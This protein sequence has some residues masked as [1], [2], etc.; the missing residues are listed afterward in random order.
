MGNFCTK[1]HTTVIEMFAKYFVMF[2]VLRDK[3][4]VVFGG[5]WLTSDGSLV[6]VF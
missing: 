6:F 5:F 1:V 3:E 4:N 2:I